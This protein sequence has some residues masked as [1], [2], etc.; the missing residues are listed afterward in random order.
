MYASTMWICPSQILNISQAVSRS[1]HDVAHR[2]AP[3]AL[4]DLQRLLAEV[5][6][7]LVERA[8]RPR[9]HRAVLEIPGGLRRLAT[10]RRMASR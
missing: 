10:L 9:H 5:V 8:A 3:E 1:E 4:E 7:A 2:D 6:A